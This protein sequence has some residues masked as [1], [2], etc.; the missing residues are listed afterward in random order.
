MKI[1]RVNKKD[2][3]QIKSR[4]WVGETRTGY[5]RDGTTGDKRGTRGTDGTFPIN[6][7]ADIPILER[8]DSQNGIALSS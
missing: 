1:T 2:K 7:L 6:A 8:L 3:L 5:K 4:S